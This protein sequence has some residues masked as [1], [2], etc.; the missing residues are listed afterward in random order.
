MGNLS[1]IQTGR[2]RPGR[3]L[4]QHNPSRAA[5]EVILR[6]IYPDGVATARK[7]KSSSNHGTYSSTVLIPENHGDTAFVALAVKFI[8]ADCALPS[9]SARPKPCKPFSHSRRPAGTM[10]ELGAVSTALSIPPCRSSSSLQTMTAAAS[11]G[12]NVSSPAHERTFSTSS[13]VAISPSLQCVD[14]TRSA[15]CIR[16]VEPA[17]IVRDLST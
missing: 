7:L 3:I 15:V 1:S 4:P 5:A 9:A 10:C 8:P 13:G 14:K 6:H 17:S 11:A 2:K 16:E 12:D